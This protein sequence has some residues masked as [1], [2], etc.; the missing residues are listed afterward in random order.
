MK[1]CYLSHLCRGY[2]PP[3]PPSLFRSFVAGKGEH[4]ADTAQIIASLPIRHSCFSLQAPPSL[5][6]RERIREAGYPRSG[7]RGVR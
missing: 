7:W 2:L 5:R 6:V 3:L 1:F 4:H